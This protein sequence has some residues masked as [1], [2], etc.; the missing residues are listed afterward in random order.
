M[1]AQSM[2][3][4][5]AKKIQPVLIPIVFILFAIS[6][7]FEMKLFFFLTLTVLIVQ[8]VS[9]I[10]RAYMWVFLG[11]LFTLSLINTPFWQVLPDPKLKILNLVLLIFSGGIWSYYSAS[12][13]S[14]KK[15]SVPVIPLIVLTGCILAVNSRPLGID[16][17]WRGDEFFHVTENMH[18]IDYIRGVLNAHTPFNTAVLALYLNHCVSRSRI[19][20]SHMR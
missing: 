11:V 16:I 14:R 5:A 4:F 15:I 20:Y 17:A 9:T 19:F 12:D 1:F 2:R 8:N 6:P 3:I 10:K 13:V 7:V 18:L